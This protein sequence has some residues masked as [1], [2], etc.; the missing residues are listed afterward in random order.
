MKVWVEFLIKFVMK[1][2]VVIL[3]V[4]LFGVGIF[5]VIKVD[6][7]FDRRILVKDDSYLK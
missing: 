7:I 3:L 5:G 4:V 2:V 1:I 6:E